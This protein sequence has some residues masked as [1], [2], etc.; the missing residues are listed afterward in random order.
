VSGVPPPLSQ[1]CH[2]PPSTER[3]GYPLG[4]THL[5]TVSCGLPTITGSS[6]R[7]LRGGLPP[8]IKKEDPRS[9]PLFRK[10]RPPPPPHSA[11]AGGTPLVPPSP[12]SFPVDLRLNAP[13]REPVPMGGGSPSQHMWHPPPP[14]HPQ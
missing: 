9:L 12:P 6:R 2:P 5:A 1:R 7:F 13:S 10:A 14:H 3:M 4:S 11:K 8:L